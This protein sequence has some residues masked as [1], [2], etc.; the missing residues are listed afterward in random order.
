MTQ[1]NHNCCV[2]F[3]KDRKILKHFIYERGMGSGIAVLL[4]TMAKQILERYE[5][6]EKAARS[7]VLK[8]F[9]AI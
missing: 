8:V 2:N 4:V 9:E 6:S 7:N 1:Q 3:G 5:Y